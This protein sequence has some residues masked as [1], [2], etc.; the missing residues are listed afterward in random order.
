MEVG[1]PIRSTSHQAKGMVGIGGMSRTF[2]DHRRTFSRHVESAARQRSL[3]DFEVGAP[4]RAATSRRAQ[5]SSARLW[6]NL[7]SVRSHH[8]SFYLLLCMHGCLLFMLVYLHLCLFVCRE[9][10]SAPKSAARS[11]H[12]QSQ[13]PLPGATDCNSADRWPDF[14]PA[15]LVA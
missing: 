10:G 2:L 9:R 5:L 15:C 11:V 1:G 12:L 7:S 8:F 6:A 13:P 4:P 3:L 14:A